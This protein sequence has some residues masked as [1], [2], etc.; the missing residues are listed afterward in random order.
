MSDCNCAKCEKRKRA[1]GFFKRCLLEIIAWVIVLW[2]V[3]WSL[4]G[5]LWTTGA[6]RIGGA[7]AISP[8]SATS[9][10]TETV[11]V[12]CPHCEIEWREADLNECWE[13]DY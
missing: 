4:F 1:W 3:G 9:A 6:I 7:V 2:V 5:L 8:A 10:T 13:G 11:R 12:V